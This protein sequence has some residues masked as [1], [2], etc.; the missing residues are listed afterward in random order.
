MSQSPVQRAINTFVKGLITE[1]SPL[2]FP[3]NASIDEL[4]CELSR[5]GTRSRRKAIGFEDA[6]EYSSFTATVDDTVRSVT[7]RS[8]GTS[9]ALDFEV[10]QV[11]STLYFYDKSVSNIS[12][13]RKSFTV[14][15]NTFKV[16]GSKPINDFKFDGDTI[17]G[18]F[19]VVHPSCDPFY[20]EYDNDTDTI[21]T[22]TIP[23]KIRDFEYL[24]SDKETLLFDT[25]DGN[26]TDERLYDS[27]N[28]GW[29]FD[30]DNINTKLSDVI[31]LSNTVL[32]EYRVTKG[33]YPR[34]THPW[35][36]SKEANGDFFVTGWGKVYSGNN[37]QGNGHFILNLFRK[38]RASVANIP[39]LATEL[40]TNRFSAIT[41][42]AGRIWYSGI[43]I[44]K[45]SGRIYFS[46]VIEE[47]KDFGTCHQVNDPTA[48]D[49]SDLLDSDGGVINIPEARNIKS[50]FTYGTTL[51]VFAE[52]G[53]WE[54]GGVDQVFKATEYYVNRV[55]SVGVYNR[56]TFVDAEGT[57]IWWGSTGIFTMSRNEISS[58]GEAAN[59][60][61]ATI[62]TFW[63]AIPIA[64]RNN[65]LAIYD[66][67]NRRIYWIYSDDELT[68][69]QY[70]KALVMD[71]V[72]EAFFPWEF[73]KKTVNSPII[74]GGFNVDGLGTVEFENEVIASSP[75]VLVS[76]DTVVVSDSQ[77]TVVSRPKIKFIVIDQ[78]VNKITFAEI[79]QTSLQDWGSETYSSYAVAGYD[80]S[81]DLTSFK[82]PLYI[83]T[84]MDKRAGSSLL[85][86][87][88]WDY[89]TNLSSES[90]LYRNTYRRDDTVVT[91]VRVRG[92][93]RVVTMRFESVGDGDFA[94]H[95]YEVVNVKNN[96]L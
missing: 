93:G 3:E 90:Q 67:V 88:Y 29:Y 92:R 10:V 26:I 80:Y 38:D 72:L 16:T 25:N 62:Q 45:E 89:K 84:V 65:A 2:T 11:N 30:D 17:N 58:N 69:R 35:Y 50:L 32:W 31:T 40:I 96:G 41:S 47:P 95:G 33:R 6:Y 75:T 76:G 8:V 63:E 43:N 64:V 36:S 85:M 57:P 42:Y 68:P 61:L 70:S 77:E 34:L 44:P 12:S 28:S 94:L 79:S 9:G 39:G 21:S 59:L 66:R 13:N 4:N 81:G 1:A 53:V 18:Y 71:L 14:N 19:V 46:K 15:L 24:T 23:I 22:S 54:I 52:N 20:I 86:K 87:T 5:T 55:S 82:N 27:Y 7:W 91:R 73:K 51:L 48:E 83:T 60:S 78:S 56:D 74:V 37:L 49:I